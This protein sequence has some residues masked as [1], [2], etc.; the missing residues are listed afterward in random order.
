MSEEEIKAFW[1]WKIN[2]LG[3]RVLARCTPWKVYA[4]EV[5]RLRPLLESLAPPQKSTGDLTDFYFWK[6]AR[7]RLTVLPDE[8][9]MRAYYVQ[10]VL[11]P[12]YRAW[13]DES[14]R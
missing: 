6:R 3:R 4:A 1:E 14:V 7:P 8:D 13:R 12:A 9:K 2:D 10:N 5:E 11:M